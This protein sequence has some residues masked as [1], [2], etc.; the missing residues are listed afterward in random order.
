M[1]SLKFPEKVDTPAQK[2]I[3]N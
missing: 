2:K 1:F 3:L